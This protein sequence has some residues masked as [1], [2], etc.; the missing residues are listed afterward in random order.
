MPQEVHLMNIPVDL[1]E[2]NKF[3][4]VKQYKATIDEVFMDQDR[5]PHQI[6][7]SWNGKSRRIE[8]RYYYGTIIFRT[9]THSYEGF[10]N[11]A[12]KPSL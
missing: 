11:D 7:I 5:N 2:T 12:E 9:R 8:P 1:Y 3:G 10:V 6:V 4:E